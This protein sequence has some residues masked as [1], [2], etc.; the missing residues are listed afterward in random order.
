MGDGAG[1][2]TMGTTLS[3]S[4]HDVLARASH[5]T[6]RSPYDEFQKT[7]ESLGR[8]YTDTRTRAILMTEKFVD[9]LHQ[10]SEY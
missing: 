3:D 6:Q 4:R 7:G 8:L 5:R 10:S 2:K 9:L 1:G